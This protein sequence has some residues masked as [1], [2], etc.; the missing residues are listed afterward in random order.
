M[1]GFMNKAIRIVAIAI[2]LSSVASLLGACKKETK[3]ATVGD[4]LFPIKA[5]T[6]KDC[7][8]APW[9]VTEK[10]GFFAQEGI[11]IVYT[12]ETQPALVLPSVLKGDNDVAGD[13]PNALAVAKAGGAKI[14]GVMRSGI[15][16][17][18]DLNP[19]LRHMFWYVNPEKYPDVK[20]FADLKKLPG[21]LK[22]S[23][24]TNNICSD[25]LANKIADKYGI[26]RDKFEWVTMPDIQAIQALKQGLVDVAGVHPPF[27]KPMAIS[28][29]RK[30]SDSL[31]TGLGPAAGVAFNYFRDDFIEKHPDVVRGFI[32]AMGRGGAWINDHPEM[33]AKWTSEAIGVPVTGNHY[34]SPKNDILESEIEPWI[35][36]LE[37]HKV[38]PRG[39]VKP[40]DLVSH[41]FETHEVYSW[42]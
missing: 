28:G 41:Q 34:Y 31:E 33:A 13:H 22:F 18:P 10:L 12:G 27:Y 37:E 30:I 17:S 23:T 35:Q 11:R 4:G 8:L 2:A 29:A 1:P 7:S 24:I 6:R 16:P 38:I 9:L 39:K 32:R 36:D 3:G 21:K 19:E 20:S 42:K 40:S 14:T 25:F 26:P 5:I 15:D